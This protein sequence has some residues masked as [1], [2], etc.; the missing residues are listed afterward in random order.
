LPAAWTG[1]GASH[2]IPDSAEA[3]ATVEISISAATYPWRMI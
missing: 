2:P 1:S 3:S